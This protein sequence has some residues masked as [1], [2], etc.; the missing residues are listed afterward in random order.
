MTTLPYDKSHYSS[1]FNEKLFFQNLKS[2]PVV[3]SYLAASA[4][5]A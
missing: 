1:N 2:L 3:A 5:Q 4:H